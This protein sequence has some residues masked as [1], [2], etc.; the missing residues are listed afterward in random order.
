MSKHAI[1]NLLREVVGGEGKATYLPKHPGYKAR[2]MTSDSDSG[3]SLGRK[4]TE[5]KG[6]Q[7]ETLSLALRKNS[8]AITLLQEDSLQILAVL[9]S[10]GSLKLLV[11]SLH[12][13]L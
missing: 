10:Y 5:G 2:M 7:A 4:V 1:L 8:G 12:S 9:S 6:S 3:C 11:S 13:K